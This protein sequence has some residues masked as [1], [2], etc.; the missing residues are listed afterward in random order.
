MNLLNIW[1][2][3]HLDISKKAYST[4]GC[5][6][7]NRAFHSITQVFVQRQISVDKYINDQGFVHFCVCSALKRE[8]NLT[9]KLQQSLEA[10]KSQQEATGRER[11][12][13]EDL[14]VQ[15]ETERGKVHDLNN[16]LQKEHCRT[17]EAMSSAEAE[18]RLLQQHLDQ[19]REV[20]HHLKHDLDALQVCD[21]ISPPALP[22]VLQKSEKFAF[23]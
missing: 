22:N 20:N 10:E 5:L 1:H 19:E 12:M 9:R 3:F 2:T 18:K 6:S 13:I 14:Q 21:Q 17:E 4:S 16:A 8:I 23:S 11:K 15:L 7:S